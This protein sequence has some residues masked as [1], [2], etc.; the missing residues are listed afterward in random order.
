MLEEKLFAKRFTP[1]IAITGVGG[2]GKTQ[3]VLKLLFRTK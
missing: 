2:V 1:T 3:L